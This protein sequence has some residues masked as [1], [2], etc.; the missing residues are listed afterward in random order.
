MGYDIDFWKEW[1]MIDKLFNLK[2]SEIDQK[3]VFKAEVVESI[4]QYENEIKNLEHSIV[5]TSVDRFGAISD[6]TVLEIH[7]KSLKFEITKLNARRGILI[8]KLEKINDE[9]VVLQKESEQY[10]YIL[11]E[12]KKEKYKK[13]LALEEEAASE[14]VQSSYIT[15]V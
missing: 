9:I 4:A 7:K 2:K 1:I 13:Q 6:F 3:L 11:K 15:K 8:K 12:Q 10:A 5:T 14:F